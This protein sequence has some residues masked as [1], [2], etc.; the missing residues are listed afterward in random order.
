MSG[1]RIQTLQDPKEP[2]TC[3][4]GGSESSFPP[5][6]L[7][8]RII[9]HRRGEEGKRPALVG[10]DGGEGGAGKGAGMM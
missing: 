2:L 3:S 1:V 10:R 6:H 9:L 5:V 4:T 7:Q 8:C